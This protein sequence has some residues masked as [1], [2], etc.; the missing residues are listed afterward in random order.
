MAKCKKCKKKLSKGSAFCPDCGTPVKKKHPF[1]KFLF[2]LVFIAL[3]GGAGFAYFN[4]IGFRSVKVEK[5]EGKVELDRGGEDKDIFEGLKLVTNDRVT[6]GNEGSLMLLIDSDKELLASENTRFSLK[7]TGIKNN[8]KV[9]IKLEYGSALATINEKLSE[10]SE[11]EIKTPNATC[12]V[13]GT[14]FNVA[15]DSSVAKTRVDVT[16]GVVHVEAGKNSLD[17][18]AGE[19]AEVVDET[20][21]PVVT[22]WTDRADILPY[23]QNGYVLFGAYE[24]DGDLSNGAEPIEWEVFD[25]NEN[26]TMLL[27]RYVLDAQPY[28]DSQKDVSWETSPLRAWLNDDFIENAFTEAEQ[29]Y[30]VSVDLENPDNEQYE[31]KGGSDTR[32]KVFLLSTDD[33]LTHYEYIYYDDSRKYGN[34]DQLVIAPTEY[35]VQQGIEKLEITDKTLRENSYDVN[36]YTSYIGKTGTWWWLRSPG[37]KE[38]TACYVSALGAAGWLNIAGGSVDAIHGIRPALYI[39][40]DFIGSDSGATVVVQDDPGEDEE[41]AEITDNS[42]RDNKPA[43][44]DTDDAPVN[45]D[46]WRL[47]F[48]N[49]VRNNRL[50]SIDRVAVIYVDDDDIPELAVKHRDDDEVIYV[51]DKGKIN[52]S[53]AGYETE[54]TPG[55]GHIRM[56]VTPGEPKQIQELSGRSFKTV[57]GTY[58]GWETIDFDMSESELIEYLG[59]S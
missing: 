49:A 17:L 53:D 47:S 20:V 38:N 56:T 59:G 18:N 44:N 50:G 5:W 11:F 40:K 21:T 36:T 43:E 14:T 55:D 8:G 16:K 28:N 2:F 4:L 31:V 29:A 35:A 12:S 42:D 32:D 1:R 54:Y 57:T 52:K 48:L 41:T 33:V 37:Y 9:T 30:L 34:S 45:S 25:T 6:T 19:S 39:N 23:M 58:T 26:G 15:Y 51:W 10:H 13:R 46:A 7:A 22:K 3:L 24:Q 27:S